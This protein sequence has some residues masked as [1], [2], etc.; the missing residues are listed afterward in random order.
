MFENKK[1][2]NNKKN[3]QMK[4]LFSSIDCNKFS[5]DLN[6]RGCYDDSCSSNNT[7]SFPGHVSSIVSSHNKKEG[8]VA[9]AIE[10]RKQPRKRRTKAEIMEGGSSSSSSSS[11]S[12][13]PPSQRQKQTAPTRRKSKREQRCEVAN[14]EERQRLDVDQLTTEQRTI[15]RAEQKVVD[16]SENGQKIR[17]T[18]FTT[19]NENVHKQESW[20]ARWESVRTERRAMIDTI[21]TLS[22]D[23]CKR[24]SSGFAFFQR[25]VKRE[26]LLFNRKVDLYFAGDASRAWKNLDFVARFLFG[27]PNSWEQESQLEPGDVPWLACLWSMADMLD[28]CNNPSFVTYYCSHPFNVMFYGNDLTNYPD[29]LFCI[30]LQMMCGYVTGQLLAHAMPEL[31]TLMR[32]CVRKDVA[33]PHFPCFKEYIFNNFETPTLLLQYDFRLMSCVPSEHARNCFSNG[34]CC[35]LGV[36]DMVENNV[37][38]TYFCDGPFLQLLQHAN[39][40][41]ALV[42]AVCG[43]ACDVA[44][45]PTL[46]MN[47]QIEMID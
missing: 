6:F 10:Q 16:Y 14:M 42:K 7:D 4:K 40:K 38:H 29:K 23:E 12:A 11:S 39:I 30:D 46:D 2:Y 34:N 18:T 8:V 25:N 9:P 31:L 3:S 13:Q 47:E 20:K 5:G 35:V 19:H 36:E 41:D 21:F 22:V 45:Q 28:F 26:L 44:P 37:E 24:K 27:L 43:G 17:E 1:V 33:L 15:S 32:E